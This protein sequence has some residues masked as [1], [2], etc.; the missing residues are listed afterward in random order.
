VLITTIL[1]FLQFVI[2]FQFHKTLY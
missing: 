1:A 2:T